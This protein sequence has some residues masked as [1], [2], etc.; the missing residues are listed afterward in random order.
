MDSQR[1]S[2]V[3]SSR[4]LQIHRG[5]ADRGEQRSRIHGQAQRRCT[6]RPGWTQGRAGGKIPRRQGVGGA[7]AHVLTAWK[8]A[9][10]PAARILGTP[11]G[12]SATRLLPGLLRFAQP[13][14]RQRRARMRVARQITNLGGPFPLPSLNTTGSLPAVEAYDPFKAQAAREQARVRVQAVQASGQAP[15]AGAW[16]RRVEPWPSRRCPAHPPEPA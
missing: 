2:R 4:V 12:R 3:L 9:W 5:D 16:A 13:G 14:S 10:G 7:A 15:A 6:L 11:Q 8:A 1:W